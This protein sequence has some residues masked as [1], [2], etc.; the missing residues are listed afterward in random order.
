[1]DCMNWNCFNCPLLHASICS[2]TFAG[3]RYLE[4]RKLSTWHIDISILVYRLC[5][6]ITYI[7]CCL[8]TPKC[9]HAQSYHLLPLSH[10]ALTS[11]TN[12]GSLAEQTSKVVF[13]ISLPNFIETEYKKQRKSGKGEWEYK[14]PRSFKTFR[15]RERRGSWCPT[16]NAKGWHLKTKTPL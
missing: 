16:S 8:P 15:V 11:S 12:H 5:A 3:V 4:R 6:I 1:V 2:Q 7:I 9:R 10:W 13:V 14:C